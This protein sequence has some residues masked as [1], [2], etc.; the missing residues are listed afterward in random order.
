MLRVAL[1]LCVPAVFGII[2]RD[3]PP[4]PN[5]Y[6]YSY[7]VQDPTT[8]DSKSQHEVRQGDVVTGAYTVLGPDG[9]KRTVEYTADAK[10]GY[11]AVLREDRPAPILPQPP[12]PY[13]HYY[14]VNPVQHHTP[15]P[16]TYTVR[17]QVLHSAPPND[18]AEEQEQPTLY[19]TRSNEVE[20][21]LDFDGHYFLPATTSKY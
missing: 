8:G 17:A 18:Y 12:I 4:S 21:R 20:P 16:R 10:H 2:V 15:S 7:N 11:K 19:F 3:P 14:P 9:T 1:V 5:D 13:H 6:K